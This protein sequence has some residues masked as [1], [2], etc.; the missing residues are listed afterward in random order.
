MNFG[1]KPQLNFFCWE[2]DLDV[3]AGRDI[4]AQD[5]ASAAKSFVAKCIDQTE[6]MVGPAEI[7]VCHESGKVESFY[8]GAILNDYDEIVDLASE[9]VFD[10]EMG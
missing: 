7:T 8:V 1:T 10:S 3:E 4:K 6:L 9:P 2:S 5:A